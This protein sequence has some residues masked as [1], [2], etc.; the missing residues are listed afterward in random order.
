M[1][2]DDKRDPIE[3]SKARWGIDGTYVFDKTLSRKG[4]KLNKMAFSLGDA[5]NREEYR[6]DEEAYL[7]KFALD[8][9]TKESIRKGDY[10]ALTTIHGGNIYYMLKLGAAKGDGLYKMGAQMRNETFEE[11]LNTR[12]AKGAR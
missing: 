12:N 6:R 2:N 8:E 5:K 7:A 10:L 3:E 4:Y 9:A 11:F 1:P